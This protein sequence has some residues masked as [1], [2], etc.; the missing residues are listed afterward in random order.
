MLNSLTERRTEAAS[1][2]AVN[3][4]LAE[5]NRKAWN[6][7]RAPLEAA[8]Q[9]PYRDGLD[10]DD[11]RDLYYPSTRRHDF[12]AIVA[13]GDYKRSSNASLTLPALESEPIPTGVSHSLR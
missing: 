6:L 1:T 3:A 4:D 2:T 8:S 7:P 12:E 10:W 13:F 9:S 5:R 11:F